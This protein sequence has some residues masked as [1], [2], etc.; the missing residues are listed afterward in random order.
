VAARRIQKDAD[1]AG[2]VVTHTNRMGDT[3]YLHRGTTKRG[4]PRYY[5]ARAVREGAVDEMPDGFEVS[6][7]INGVVSVRRK[8]PGGPQVPAADLQVVWDAVRL[9]PHLE[10]YEVRAVGGAIVIYEP[11]PRRDELRGA[12]MQLGIAR[13]DDA[14]IGERMKRAQYGPVMKFEGT[15]DSYAVFRMTYR[16]EGGWS[17]PLACGKLDELANQF[18][19]H[20]GTDEFYELL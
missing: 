10:D 16:G 9:C 14:Y 12:A 13:L 19:R 7:S 20:I 5:F 11:S 2:K 18:V 4:K 1:P 8:R 6:E 15:A 17:W 3:Y